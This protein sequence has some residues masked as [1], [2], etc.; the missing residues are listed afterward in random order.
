ML[1]V[2]LF[3]TVP[4]FTEE[5]VERRLEWEP[6]EGVKVVGEYWLQ[7]QDPAV[8]VV[9]EADHIRQLWATFGPWNK[10]F[11]ISIYPAVEAHEGLEMLKSE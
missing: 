5:R 3:K 4:G 6:P 7:T 11:D 10:Y 9:C 1:F 8:I 2:A